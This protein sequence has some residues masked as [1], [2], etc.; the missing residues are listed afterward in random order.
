MTIM[1]LPPIEPAEGPTLVMAVRAV[2]FAV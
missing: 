1:V 2:M